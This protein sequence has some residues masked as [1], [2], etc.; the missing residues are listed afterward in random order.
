MLKELVIKNGK[1]SM[2][3]DPLNTKYTV[4]VDNK[5]NKLN[6][7]YKIDENYSVS[8]AGN[9]LINDYNEIVITVYNDQE[10]QNYYFYVYKEKAAEV[11]TDIS[12]VTNIE[13]PKEEKISTHAVPAISSVCFLIMKF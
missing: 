10:Y 6:F 2:E 7:E 13:L 9:N 1:L 5:E 8:I 4:S 3:F 11:S 12:P